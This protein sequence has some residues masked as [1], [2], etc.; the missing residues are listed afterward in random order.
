MNETLEESAME[1]CIFCGEQTENATKICDK[2]I[3]ELA[4]AIGEMEATDD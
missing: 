1:N 3:D 4:F 2:C